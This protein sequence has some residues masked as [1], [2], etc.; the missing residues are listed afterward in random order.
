MPSMR[1]G[2]GALD[3]VEHRERE[4]AVPGEKGGELGR[5]E[6]RAAVAEGDDLVA[7]AHR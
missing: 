7:S 4:L 1:G 2:L 5:A 6:S 3:E